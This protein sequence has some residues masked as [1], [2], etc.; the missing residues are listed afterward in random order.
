LL[1]NVPQ[2]RW[3]A[4]CLDRRVTNSSRS[5]ER[6]DCVS[7]VLLREQAIAIQS[8]WLQRLRESL[9]NAR[10]LPDPVLRDSIP[11]IIETLADVLEQ[12]PDVQNPCGQRG[13][14]LFERHAEERINWSNYKPEE[15]MREYGL[16]RKVLLSV[17]EA[18]APLPL[19]ERD[20]ILDFIDQGVQIGSARFAEVQHF[21]ERLELQYLKLIEHL[22]A[23]SAETSGAGGGLERL[24]DIILTSLGAEAAAFF[25]YGED[26]LDV[27]LSSATAKSPQ[28]AELYRGALTLS[29][30]SLAN[31]E[32]RSV[33]CTTIENL[34]PEARASL[35]KLGI[36]SLAWVP[37]LA[38][39]RLPGTLCLGF[40]GQKAFDPVEL[41]LLE[42]LG[43]RLGLLLS[44]IQLQEQSRAALE[45]ARHESDML[46]AERNRLDEERQQRD[47]VI[48]A[49]SHDLKNPLHTARLGAELI[50][51][52]ATTPNATERLANQIL[53][54]IGRSDR[55]IHDLLDTQR[56]R[57][58][59]P[60]ALQIEPF[61]MEEL[62]NEV[63]DDM[64]RAHGDRFVSDLEPNVL[65]YWSRDGMRRAIENLLTNAVKYSEDKT[66]VT[67]SV[68]EGEGQKM[69]LSVHNHGPTLSLQEQARIFEPFERTKSAELGGKQ[70]WGIGLTLVKGIVQSHGGEV[71]VESLPDG[72]TTF[73]VENPMD[74]RPYQ[75]AGSA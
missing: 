57:A 1:A 18:E 75:E 24:L 64:K 36:E 7:A 9:H 28:L 58:G 12:G 55:M 40:R 2:F 32:E 21:Q 54:S 52:G 47:Q 60:L 59:K 5:P 35:Q 34:A 10:D 20:L 66:P 6:T 11:S 50:R 4:P 69:V 30:A 41:R 49:I 14:E 25:L 42:V 37:L 56:I 19:A 74:S 27:T 61:R 48:A 22:V 72:G 33:R 23:E 17:L 31:S 39:G 68:R 43:D 15:L 45:R 65:G 3:Y 71:K 46:E 13:Q 53:S 62:V 73:T 26:L 51:S 16:L 44:S 38:R 63:V 67:I 29:A 8:E 70:G